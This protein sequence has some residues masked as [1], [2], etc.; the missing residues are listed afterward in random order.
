[1]QPP[2]RGY[3]RDDKHAQVIND[4]PGLGVSCVPDRSFGMRQSD[5]TGD[6]PSVHIGGYWFA[7][8]RSVSIT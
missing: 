2:S 3:R 6:A 1:M 4:I 8:H 5:H 7:G